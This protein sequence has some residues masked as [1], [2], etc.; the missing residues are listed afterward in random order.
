MVQKVR[1]EWLP[2]AVA[3]YAGIAD[4]LLR[5]WDDEIVADFSGIIERK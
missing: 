2:E 1:I 5:I 3:S 4:F